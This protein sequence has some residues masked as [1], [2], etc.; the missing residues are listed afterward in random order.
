MRLHGERRAES[1]G[2]LGLVGALTAQ[3]YR[4]SMLGV[5]LPA[6]MDYVL[7][8]TGTLCTTLRIC[9]GVY[10]FLSDRYTKER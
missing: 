9:R 3:L 2:G 10:A 8:V 5:H 4:I 6:C 7:I 1:P